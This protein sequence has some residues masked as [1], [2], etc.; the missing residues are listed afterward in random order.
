[1]TAF[2][3]AH[4][5]MLLV[6]CIICLRQG[7]SLSMTWKSTHAN[8]KKLLDRPLVS[9][10][11]KNKPPIRVERVEQLVKYVEEDAYHVQDMDVRGS[12]NEILQKSDDVH[13]I[14]QMLHARKA[15]GPQHHNDG[16][17]IALAIEGGGMRGCVSA[18]MAA[19]RIVEQSHLC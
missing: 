16:K 6:A 3:Y 8:L 15:V 5:W 17:K 1:M 7:S 9:P 2:L 4:G 11:L 12:I 13:P 19:V 18:G 10:R 14:V